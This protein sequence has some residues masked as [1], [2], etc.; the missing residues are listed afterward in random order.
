MNGDRLL[1]FDRLVLA[2]L[3]QS[4]RVIEKPCRDCLHTV[5]AVVVV[6]VVVVIVAVVVTA[7]VVVCP[8]FT[9]TQLLQH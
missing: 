1:M 7:A 2:G 6:V 8:C 4:G 5:V 9:V 3:A